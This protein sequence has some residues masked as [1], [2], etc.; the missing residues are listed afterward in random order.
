MTPEKHFAAVR[1]LP[2]IA[3]LAI[4]G[5]FLGSP[6]VA[7]NISGVDFD[8][9][10]RPPALPEKSAPPWKRVGSI[11]RELIDV[12]GQ[13]ALQIASAPAGTGYY[14]MS[15]LAPGGEPDFSE[16]GKGLTVECLLRVDSQEGTTGTTAI[17]MSDKSGVFLLQC[18]KGGIWP[19]K[20]PQQ[21]VSL[22]LGE[23]FQ[24][25]RIVVQPG[26]DVATVYVNDNPSEVLSIPRYRN[27]KERKHVAWGDFGGSMGGQTSWQYF[28]FTN[29]GAFSPSKQ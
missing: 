18:D 2:V 12:N 20:H 10:Y 22:P 8:V 15:D 24:K 11:Q 14:E 17:R 13:P 26:A 9:V 27:D 6:C 28:A 25:I 21:K 4:F 29:H 3:L 16:S 1:Y 23:E 5:L 19:Y 7:E